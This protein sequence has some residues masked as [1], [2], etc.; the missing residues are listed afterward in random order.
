MYVI[1]SYIEYNL[2][3][4]MLLRLCVSVADVEWQHFRV[5]LETEESQY[6]TLLS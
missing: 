3:R 6:M 2:E 5:T 4:M 1:A